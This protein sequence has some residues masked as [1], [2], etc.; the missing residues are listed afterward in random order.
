MWE[1]PAVVIFVFVFK[2]FVCAYQFSLRCDIS[3]FL[4][5]ICSDTKYGDGYKTTPPPRKK[6]RQNP[7]LCGK[8][9]AWLLVANNI[10]QMFSKTCVEC[11]YWWTTWTI[12]HLDSI[13]PVN[14]VSVA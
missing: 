5:H 8:V 7:K 1:Q 2:I 14:M 9:F 10:S 6:A 3:S 13:V 4:Q 12:V 11:K